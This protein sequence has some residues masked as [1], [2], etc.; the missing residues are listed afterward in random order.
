LVLQP[1]GTNQNSGNVVNASNTNNATQANNQTN[2]LGQTQT[3]TGGGS[4]CCGAGNVTQSA[5]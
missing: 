3:V 1:G 2:G 4:G 5:D